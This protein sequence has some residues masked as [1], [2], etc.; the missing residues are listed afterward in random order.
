MGLAEPNTW[1]FIKSRIRNT[2]HRQPCGFKTG[3]LGN[4]H[5]RILNTDPDPGI[6]LTETSF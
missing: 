3:P 4:M 1:Q 5:I 6:F 2:A